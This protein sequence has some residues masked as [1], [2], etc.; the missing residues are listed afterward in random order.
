VEFI[1][2]GADMKED[3]QPGLDKVMPTESGLILK[4]VAGLRLQLKRR[5][6]NLGGYDAVKVGPYRVLPGATVLV[7]DPAV[8]LAL[9]FTDELATQIKLEFK[10]GSSIDTTSRF[11][12]VAS[13][14]TFGPPAT[15][16]FYPKASALPI[17]KPAL[18][19][20]GC[21]PYSVDRVPGVKA[22][23]VL[24]VRRGLCTF[25]IKSHRA[26]MAGARALLV[27]S[28]D[29]VEFMPA[30]DDET[31]SGLVATL[32]ISNSTGVEL[33][34]SF[35][36]A[37]DRGKGEMMWAVWA[38]EQKPRP[39]VVNGHRILNAVVAV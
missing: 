34:R 28:F 21:E 30:A 31:E 14:A 15:T 37:E 16:V 32:L 38:P 24:L 5:L 9:Q 33:E 8:N 7:T 22:G 12:G 39:F 11:V 26:A 2:F 19:V 25:Q 29:E 27:S 35:R 6:E 20:Y 1:F 18:D 4:D 13:L 23:F 36:L 3:K 10:M 17:V